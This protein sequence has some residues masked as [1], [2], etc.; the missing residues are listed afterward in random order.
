MIIFVYLDIITPVK[1][2]GLPKQ[3]GGEDIPFIK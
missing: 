2:T 1:D 3:S